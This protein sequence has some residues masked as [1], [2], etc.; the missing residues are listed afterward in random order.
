MRTTVRELVESQLRN[1]EKAEGGKLKRSEGKL[2]AKEGQVQGLR[3]ELST[4][5]PGTWSDVSSVSTFGKSP[6]GQTRPIPGNPETTR[7]HSI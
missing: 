7:T 2:E 3:R 5:H 4:G 1:Q 6:L